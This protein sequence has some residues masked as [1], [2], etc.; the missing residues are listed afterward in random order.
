MTTLAPMPP[1]P[2]KPK[3]QIPTLLQ[4]IGIQLVGVSTAVIEKKAI[5]PSRTQHLHL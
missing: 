5:L 2:T 3:P 4:S 1:S